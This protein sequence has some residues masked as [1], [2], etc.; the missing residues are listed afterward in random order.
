M[1]IPNKLT[2]LQTLSK[3]HFSEV[4]LCE[5]TYLSNRKE[6]VKFIGTKGKNEKE[7][8]K[9]LKENLFES[10]VL[11]YLKRS[12]Y[13]VEIYDA[14]ILKN[15]F[16]INMEFLE[17]GSVQELLNKHDFLSIKQIIKISEC[18]LHALEHAHNKHIL[19]LD[20][21]PGNILI[22]N[23][24][25][26]KLSDF[27]LANVK[28]KDGT[29]SFK[30]IYTAHY[31]PERLSGSIK[32]ATEQSDIYMFGVTLYRLLNGE[33]HFANQWND[34]KNKKVL[35]NSIISGKFPDRKKYLS[36]IHR[37]IKK[38]VNKCLD[39]DLSK[40]YKNIRDIRNDFGKIKMKYCWI[41]KN[42]TVDLQHWECFSD[43]KTFLELITEKKDGFWDISLYKFGPS[44]KT[45]SV[46]HCGKKIKDKEFNKS[47]NKIF[48]EF[49]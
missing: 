41:P 42:I 6:A 39:I 48:N 40:R 5:N 2:S 8:V 36:H 27:G 23:E 14:T 49:L 13:I 22:K 29:S 4:F 43:K 17:K 44:K 20:V 19:H 35:K 11:E 46:R 31:P 47:I 37:K 9:E 3:G 16:R 34:K 26:Y 30:K 38:I 1:D 7:K 21:K 28:R 25:T 33:S 15:G 24:N 12:P 18:V 32:E 10:T 45:R